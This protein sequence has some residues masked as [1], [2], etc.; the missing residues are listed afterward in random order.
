MNGANQ[1]SGAAAADAAA[2][3]PRLDQ[4]YNVVCEHR[5]NLE[6]LVHRLEQMLGRARG[7]SP[8]EA[9]AKLAENPPTQPG[10]INQLEE[11]QADVMRL[12]VRAKQALGELESY[13]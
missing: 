5:D 2:P 1:L 12:I 8:E 11:R 7:P 9:S 3:N 4:I 6:N 10:F 13:Y